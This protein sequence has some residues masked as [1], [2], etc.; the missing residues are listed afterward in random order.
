MTRIFAR[1][2]TVLTVCIMLSGCAT[3]YMQNRGNDLKD[4]LDIGLTVS[5]Q[6]Q[7]SLYLDFFNI[8]PLGY[9]HV[10]TDK[11][12]KIGITHRDIGVVPYANKSWG[13]L[14]WGEEYRGAEAF[15]PLDPHE[16]R[17]DQ[18]DLTERSSYKVGL[19]SL[20]GEGETP[21]TLQFLE[22][23]RSLHLG[24]VGVHFLFRP[25]D[26]LDFVVGLTTVDIL[27]D[28][29]VEPEAEE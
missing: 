11:V 1:L 29:L 17:K 25:V 14:L 9:S 7:F 8:V 23:E 16:A 26:L 13:A 27:G 2:L 3:P 19:V 5:K 10:D 28:D 12:T 4:I 22:C 21:P 6:P 20:A 15:N 24:W 18:A